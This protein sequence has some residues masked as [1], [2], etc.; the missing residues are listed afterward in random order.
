MQETTI[1][2]EIKEAHDITTDGTQYVCATV[3]YDGKIIG[4]ITVNCDVNTVE[5]EI[6]ARL[7]EIKAKM[8]SRKKLSVGDKIEV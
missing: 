4:E 2:A 1:T 5:Q 7:Q 8:L 3:F 6:E